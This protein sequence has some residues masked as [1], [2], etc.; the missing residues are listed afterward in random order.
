MKLPTIRDPRKSSLHG[1]LTRHDILANRRA[2]KRWTPLYKA[3]IA[4]AIRGRLLTPEEAIEQF[5]TT[6]AELTRWVEAIEKHG[7]R[8]LMAN[9]FAPENV[10]PKLADLPTIENGRVFVDVENR[11]LRIDGVQVFVTPN[12]FRFLSLL[13][14]RAP[15]SVS[16]D[17]AY[18]FLY[19]GETRKPAWKILDV[20]VCKL[21][22]TLGEGA[23]ETVWGR[24]WRWNDPP[25]PSSVSVF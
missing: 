19:D 2:S 8:G 20:M 16:R 24:G 25:A 4:E 1:P 3:I 21:R 12:Q 14:Y 13:I 7:V 17:E 23:I 6:A 9:N 15:E 10:A 5:G 18:A 22:R 11:I